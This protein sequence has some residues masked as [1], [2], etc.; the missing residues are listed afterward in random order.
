[1]RG[2]WILPVAPLTAAAQ[3]PPPVPIGVLLV[4]AGLDAA[5]GS[6]VRYARTIRAVASVGPP[7]IVADR[8]LRGTRTRGT[9]A[10]GGD[11]DFRGGGLPAQQPAPG[12]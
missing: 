6:L 3:F 5:A 7:R 12:S 10:D 11:A 4:E 9:G 2:A 8:H 1:M